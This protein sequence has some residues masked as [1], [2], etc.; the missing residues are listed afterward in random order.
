M[1]TSLARYKSRRL[2]TR[3]APSAI[4]LNHS[5]DHLAVGC[6]NGDIC[7]WKLPLEEDETTADHRISFSDW[8]G[9]EVSSILWFSDTLATFGRGN[10]LVAVTKLNYVSADVTTASTF[11][12]YGFSESTE[13]QRCEF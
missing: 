7:F 6:D 12:P 10:G 11:T 1:D 5:G 13:P 9:V 2:E 8:D 4:A 3:G